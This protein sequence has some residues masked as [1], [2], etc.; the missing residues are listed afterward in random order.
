MTNKSEE[1][2]VWLQN[3]YL[4]NCNDDW[5]H[6]YGIKINNLDNPGWEVVI[7]LEETAMENIHFRSIDI[8]R[9][10]NNWFHCKVEKLKFK[11]YCGA[12]NLLEVLE[13]FRSWVTAQEK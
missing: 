4:E 5:E 9:D 13:I 10:K 3:W 7:D 11:G 1:L 8:E 2:M 6:T 12:L